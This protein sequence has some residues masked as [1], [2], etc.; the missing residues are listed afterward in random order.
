LNICAHQQSNGRVQEPID[1]CS[2]AAFR[3]LHS[4]GY[5]I[6]WKAGED[7][8]FHKFKMQDTARGMDLHPDGIQVAAVHW[9]K[10]VSLCRL[11]KKSDSK[12]K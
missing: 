7:K 1:F 12:K 8:A 4:G 10:K 9:N 3:V 5:L 6:F 11:E 2:N